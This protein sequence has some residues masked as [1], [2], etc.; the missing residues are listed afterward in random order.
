MHRRHMSLAALMLSGGGADVPLRAKRYVD[1]GKTPLGPPRPVGVGT[2]AQLPEKETR[3]M[4][5][6]RERAEAKRTGNR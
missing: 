2:V 3:Q 6:A 1:P 5:R 4:R